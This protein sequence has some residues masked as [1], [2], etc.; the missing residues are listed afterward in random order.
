MTQGTGHLGSRGGAT[1]QLRDQVSKMIGHLLDRLVGEGLRVGL[2]VLH[3]LR[4]I[5]PSRGERRIARLPE[6]RR[7]SIPTR[8]APNPPMA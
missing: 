3:R 1:L 4:V 7:P 5:R 8:S 6:Q 2:G